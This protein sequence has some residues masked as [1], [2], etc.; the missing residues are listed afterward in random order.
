[1]FTAVGRATARRIQAPSAHPAA[2]AQ[3]LLRQAPTTSALPIRAFSASAPSQLPAASEKKS[4]ATAKNPA[5]KKKP[6]AT[7]K[8]AAPVAKKTTR[9][10]KKEVDPEENKKAEIRQLKKWA[11]RDTPAALPHTKWAQFVADNKDVLKGSAGLGPHMAG[12][13]SKFH[14]LSAAEISNLE[15]IAAANREKNAANLKAWIKTHE[16]ARIHIA[17]QARRRLTKLTDKNYRVFEDDR[18]PKRPLSSYTNF[19]VENW[20]RLGG[21]DAIDGSKN[22]SEAWKAL[23]PSEKAVYEEKTAQASAK[24]EAEMEVIQARADAIKAEADP[25]SKK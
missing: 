4:K 14:S 21:S 23:S 12:L 25:K 1:M 20:P 10:P 9:K 13:S 19:T 22:I 18:L 7:T 2:A 5:A 11:L 24:Y 3:L 6:A 15:N 8:K 16:P 17:N